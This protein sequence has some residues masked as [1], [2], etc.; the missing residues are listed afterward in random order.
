LCGLIREHS[1]DPITVLSADDL[2]TILQR[3]HKRGPPKSYG[4]DGEVYRK[5]L[6]KVKYYKLDK[7]K[8]SN[9]FKSLRSMF[10]VVQEEIPLDP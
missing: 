2:E 7:K 8:N 10:Q 9:I 5:S 4:M 3:A 6:L 1:L